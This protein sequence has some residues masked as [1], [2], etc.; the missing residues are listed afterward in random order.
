MLGA[1][2]SALGAVIRNAK[3]G[4]LVSPNGHSAALFAFYLLTPLHFSVKT[5]LHG[6]GDNLHASG[7]P[8]Y[9][10][11][12]CLFALLPFYFSTRGGCQPIGN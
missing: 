7:G 1:V 8:L 3:A 11:A 10:T 6:R 4:L 5:G 9:P 2:V 12:F